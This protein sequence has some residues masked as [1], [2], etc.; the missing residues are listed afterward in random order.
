MTGDSKYFPQNTPRSRSPSPDP[1]NGGLLREWARTG[2]L[3][4]PLG[5]LTKGSG[6]SGGRFPIR[7]YS[8]GNLKSAKT[9]K[10]RTKSMLRRSLSTGSHATVKS[11]YEA[12]SRSNMA[13]LF[14]VSFPANPEEMTRVREF[15][16]VDPKFKQRLWYFAKELK[17]LLAVEIENNRLY[18]ETGEYPQMTK[19]QKEGQPPLDEEDLCCW[20]GLEHV[21][22]GEDRTLRIRRTV[23]GIVHWHEDAK[24][25]GYNDP[26]EL[27]V[28]AKARTKPDRTR[29]QK[30][31]QQDASYI[32]KLLKAEVAGQEGH[33][34]SPNSSHKSLV[35]SPKKMVKR[36]SAKITSIPTLHWSPK[37]SKK[38]AA[39]PIEE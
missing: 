38:S 2:D 31:A 24:E 35:S 25:M 13:S 36:L 17:Y 32:K 19:E 12:Y 6:S 30:R 37:P 10:L 11:D 1:D 7:N 20:R 22:D 15:D 14:Q 34:G 39:V 18:E 5:S 29:A 16:R 4:V 8:G 26:D 21:W 27:R 28:V 23:S 33:S 9:K 3:G